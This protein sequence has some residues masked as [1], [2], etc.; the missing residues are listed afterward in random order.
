[1][2]EADLSRLVNKVM[3]CRELSGTK[4]GVAISIR[5]MFCPND[6][7]LDDRAH[8]SAF[9]ILTAR[10]PVD[11]C[12]H[13]EHPA[14][15]KALLRRVREDALGSLANLHNVGQ[16]THS[17]SKDFCRAS[18]EFASQHID[19]FEIASSLVRN[20]L[21]PLHCS[22]AKGL[23]AI[24]LAHPVSKAAAM[25]DAISSSPPKLCEISRT[26]AR[27]SFRSAKD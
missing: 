24:G 3:R 5:C 10:I 2:V 23:L 9:I 20:R 8:T 16:L 17:K 27:V 6:P 25:S 12:R 14:I 18:G 13:G 15:R 19:R 4:N 11:L 1:M 21:E 7:I 22:I 26:S